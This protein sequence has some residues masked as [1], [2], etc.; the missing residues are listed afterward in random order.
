MR[1]SVIENDNGDDDEVFFDAT[2]DE[3]HR[4]E[5]AM[6]RRMTAQKM[7]ERD[8]LELCGRW[9]ASIPT[10]DIPSLRQTREY[11]DFL[12]AF[13][14]LGQAHRRVVALGRSS[15]ETDDPDDRSHMAPFSFLQHLVKDDVLMRVFEYLGSHSLVQTSRVCARFRELADISAT[16]R[17]QDIAPIRQ[18]GHAMQLLRAKEQIDGVG[19]FRRRISHVS[20]P[21]LAMRQRILVTGAGDADFNGV[22]YCTGTNGNGFVYTKPRTSMLRASMPSLLSHAPVPL[23]EADGVDIDTKIQ[24]G[25]A[26][27]VSDMKREQHRVL[28][29]DSEN[30]VKPGDLLRCIISK[31]FSDEVRHTQSVPMQLYVPVCW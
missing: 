15:M 6:P 23:D 5:S 19:D 14:R 18:L 3:S 29:W 2:V 31:R 10:D 17:T 11:T 30:A 28:N 9:L 26:L 1:G 8:R 27:S 25:S 20:V 13:E 21:L 16:Q 22:Y 24:Q 4:D 7:V 12:K